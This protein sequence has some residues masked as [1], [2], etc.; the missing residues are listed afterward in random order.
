MPYD[1]GNLYAKDSSGVCRGTRY[2]K[3]Y[4]KITQTDWQGKPLRPWEQ[5]KYKKERKEKE[6]RKRED[7]I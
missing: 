6:K 2:T 7:D 5:V 4:W 1:D 3:D